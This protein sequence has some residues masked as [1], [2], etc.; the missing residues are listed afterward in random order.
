MSQIRRTALFE[1]HKRK[2]ARMAPFAGY[3]MPIQYPNG[4]LKEHIHTRTAAGLFDVSHMGQVRFTGKDREAFIEWVTPADVQALSIGAS[5]LSSITTPEGGVMDDCIITRD[6]DYVHVVINAGC[7]DKDIAYFTKKLEE[8]GKNVKMEVLD[9]SLIALQGPKAATVLSRYLDDLQKLPFMSRRDGVFIDNIPVRVTRCGYTGEDGF[10]IS[11][12]NDEAER[13]TELLLTYDDVAMI[14]LGARDSLRTEAGMCL[15]GH[16][17][18]ETMNPV[19]ARLLWT[20][21]KRRM[22]EGGFVGHERIVKFKESKELVPRL[23]V[24]IVSKGP[25]AREKAPVVV[26]GKEIGV[27]TSGCPSPTLGMNV[28]MAYVDRALANKGTKVQLNVRNKLVD[29]EIVTL[30]FVPTRY[31]VVS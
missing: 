17:L 18:D 2:L 13:L 15:Y 11:V 30:P 4:I 6:D 28:A 19:A 14:G 1:L 24:G 31:H 23:R 12:S 27:V 26:E 25:V 8:F 10:E 22:T 5:R 9:K 3:E 16:E 7:K 20:I 29:G 21:T